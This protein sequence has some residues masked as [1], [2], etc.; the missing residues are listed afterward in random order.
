MN[1]RGK[2]PETSPLL[3]LTDRRLDFKI[4]SRLFIAWDFAQGSDRPGAPL[5]WLA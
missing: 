5:F 3:S 2:L 4:D 1:C